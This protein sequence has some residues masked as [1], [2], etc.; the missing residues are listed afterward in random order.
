MTL[1]PHVHSANLTLPEPLNCLTELRNFSTTLETPK[2]YKSYEFERIIAVMFFSQSEQRPGS[3]SPG[4]SRLTQYQVVVVKCTGL[5]LQVDVEITG[6][7]PG[8]W[9]EG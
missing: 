2:P 9:D 4:M 1:L 5:G 3:S 7:C 8:A 6:L